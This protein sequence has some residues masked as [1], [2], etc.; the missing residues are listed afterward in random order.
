MEIEKVILATIK[1]N[2][3]V[4]GYELNGILRNSDRYFLT[5]SLSYIYPVLKSLHQRGLVAYTNIPVANRLDKKSYHITRQG[6]EALNEWLKE[7]IEPDMYFK[8]FLLKMQFAPMMDN[9]T[10]LNHINREITRLEEKNT[11]I[12]QLSNCYNSGKLDKRSS[13]VLESMAQILDKT[14]DLRIQWLKE[15]KTREEKAS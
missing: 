12:G 14:N 10:I 11:D 5:V 3:E 6:E 13:E 1:A 15:W 4:T 8:S 9:A 2:K 7:P